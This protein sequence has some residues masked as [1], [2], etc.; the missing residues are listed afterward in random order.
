[1]TFSAITLCATSQRVFIFVVVVV[2]YVF[3]DSVRKLL[4]IP[5]Y[6]CVSLCYGLLCRYGP[7]DGQI[8]YPRS[9]T[10]I[11]KRK[12]RFPEI[13]SELEHARVKRI[14]I[15]CASTLGIKKD[16]NTEGHIK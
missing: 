16:P 5:W 11:F 3:I 2:V 13:N 1:V 8:L 12:I 15:L 7:Y 6:V 10:K 9:H 14:V 4:D